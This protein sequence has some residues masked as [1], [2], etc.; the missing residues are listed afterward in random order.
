MYI[1]LHTSAKIPDPGTWRFLGA[2]PKPGALE[3]GS[4]IRLGRESWIQG[5]GVFGGAPGS[6]VEPWLGYCKGPEMAVRCTVK[7]EVKTP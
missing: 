7:T 4:R 2:R 3:P 1:C 6:E 5:P